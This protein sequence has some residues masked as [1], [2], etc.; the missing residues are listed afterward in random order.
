MDMPAAQRIPGFSHK[1]HGVSL[2]LAFLVALQVLFWTQTHK[3]Q[4]KLEVVPTPPGR[5]SVAAFTFGDDQFYFRILAL[6]LQN[7]G[8][9][10]GR[11]T[12]LRYYD[13]SKLYQWLIL[14]DTLDARSNVLPTLAANYFSQTQNTPDIRY[15]ADYLEQ[16]ATRDI[17][18]KWWWLMQALYL[19]EYKLQDRA[20]S[21]E[22]ADK[23]VHPDV[24]AFAQQLAAVVYE[25]RGEMDTALRIMQ[26]IRDNANVITDADLRYMHYFI[27]ERIKRLDQLKYFPRPPD[28]PP[29]PGK[30]K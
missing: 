7:F 20:L 9:T 10:F 19:S 14:L 26:T 15:M 27:E 24:P 2:L 5:T 13:F 21:T 16:H 23:L 18:H 4:P 11:F 25:K 12:A 8:D 29:P 1:A 6:D 17:S 28:A 30:E 3:L 22:L